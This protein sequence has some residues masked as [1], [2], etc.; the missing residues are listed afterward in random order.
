MARG[1]TAPNIKRDAMEKVWALYGKGVDNATISAVVGISAPSVYRII[2]IMKLAKAHDVEGL[3]EYRNGNNIAQKR[4]AC[5][6]FGYD[7]DAELRSVDPE[8]E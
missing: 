7:F 4:M 8:G 3:C 2:E 1:R 6:H 5:K